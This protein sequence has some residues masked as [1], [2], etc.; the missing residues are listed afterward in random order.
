MVAIPRRIFSSLVSLVVVAGAAP[1]AYTQEPDAPTVDA[2]SEPAEASPIT[3]PPRGTELEEIIVTAQRRRENLQD[4]PLS[5]ATIGGDAFGE[6]RSGGLDVRM[7]SSRIPSLTLESSFGRTFPR[8]YIRG[9]G[10]TDFDLNAS[11]PVSL[12]LDDVV[13]ENPTIKGM[14]FFDVE[15]VEVLR[16]PQGTLFGRNTP[17]G[18]VKVDS[19]E[20]GQTDADYWR[21][22]YGRF[23]FLGV[24]GGFE[25]PAVEDLIA[26]RVSLLFERRDN[27][28]KNTYTDREHALEGFNDAAARFQV[29]YTPTSSSSALLNMHTHGLEGTARLFR[30][31]IIRPEE[32]GLVDDFRRDEVAQDGQNRQKLR[33]LGA[34]LTLT[35]DA[36]PMTLTAISGYENVRVYSRGDIDGGY[37]AV[38]APPSGPGLIPFSSESADGIP[39]HEQLTQEVRLASNDWDVV[40]VQVGGY[41]FY[42]DLNIDSF[43]YNTFAGGVENGYAKQ[44]QKTRS[45]AVFGSTTVDAT[46]AL[47]FGAGV[48]FTDEGK[49]FRATRLVS[50]IGTGPIGP[51]KASPDDRQI[52][53]DANVNYRVVSDVMVFARAAKGFRAPS[54]QGRILFGDSLS[55]AQSETLMSVDAGIKSEL[56]ER[57]ARINLAGFYYEIRDQQLTAVGGAANFNQLLNADRSIGYGFELDAHFLPVAGLFATLGVSYNHTEIKDDTLAVAPCSG[58]CKVTDPAG[59]VAGT[60][61][62]GGNPLPHAPEWIAN[63]TLRYGVPVGTDA[64]VF[65]FTDW[66]YRSR[67]NFFLYESKE[68]TDAYLLEGSVRLGYSRDA[69]HMELAAFVRNVTNDVSLEGGIDFNNLTGFVNEPRFYGVEGLFRF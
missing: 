45:A 66:A 11:Q 12:V 19:R 13:L 25:G 2:T 49:T 17:A 5:V 65:A 53:W 21:L 43:S 8:F 55:V 32:G 22:T 63:A 7:L 38:Y 20:P 3:P 48:R 52:S 35:H 69:G 59:P 47:R 15:H 37:G 46:R 44:R 34:G 6:L 36:G 28:V 39:R 68:F 16:G 10:N 30:A 61:L 40:N 62:I 23:A 4:V 56:F 51:L 41:Y 33:Q 54:I 9:L 29:L 14:P 26:T 50:P 18:V 27:W 31:N 67:I 57:R 58:G 1:L 60:V 42:E 64:E 24:E